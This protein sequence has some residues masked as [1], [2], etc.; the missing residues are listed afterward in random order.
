MLFVGLVD[1]SVYGLCLCCSAATPYPLY[2]APIQNLPTLLRARTPS[3]SNGSGTPSIGAVHTMDIR[4]QIE[5]I[6][7]QL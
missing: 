3:L 4:R 7:K 6:G 2:K 1:A 5:Q